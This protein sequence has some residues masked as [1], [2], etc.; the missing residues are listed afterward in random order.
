MTTFIITSS[1][2]RIV[3]EG[4]QA[5]A[6]VFAES[7]VMFTRANKLAQTSIG[8]TALETVEGQF[9]SWRPTNGKDRQPW[10]V[11]GAEVFPPMVSLPKRYIDR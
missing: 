7:T 8:S 6:F 4:R 2:F 11:I 10:I 5:D 3:P 9:S 1:R